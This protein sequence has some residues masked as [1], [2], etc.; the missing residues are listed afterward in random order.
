MD[1]LL[2][3]TV[4]V[5]TV[6]LGS[7]SAA[8]EA[9]NMSSQL[10]GKHLRSLEQLLDVKLLNRTTRRQ[11]LTDFGVTYYERAKN[12]LLEITTA[13]DL[14]A[15]TRTI[16][17]GKL[18]INASVSFGVNA[19]APALI[20]YMKRYPEVKVELTATNRVVDVIEEGFDVVFRIGHL[21][22]SSLISRAL[23]PYR[24]VLCAAPGYL[25]THTPITTPEDLSQHECMGFLPNVQRSHWTFDSSRGQITV[26]VSGQYM[27]DSG[28]AMV[29]AA[30]ADLG[31]IVQPLELVMNHLESGRLVALLQDY[32]VPSVPMHLI[33]P[34]DRRMT[35]KLRSFIDFAL[36]TF[37]KSQMGL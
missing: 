27:S 34:P 11:H 20:T 2:S 22:D 1:K 36:A 10:A 33:Y 32:P 37:S 5:K 6:E 35:P 18:R 31:I 23:A 29:A 19:L 24:L 16:P 25:K 9:L 7:L 26:P 15:A 30:L 4:F 8:G 3:M 13:E 21:T 17:R 14:A 12:I 28:E